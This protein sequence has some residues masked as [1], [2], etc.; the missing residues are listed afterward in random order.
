[1]QDY[2]K[3]L[4]PWFKHLTGLRHALA[5]RIPLYIPQ[6]VIAKS[7]EGAYMDYETKMTEA[8]KQQEF[9]EYDRLSAEQMKLGRFRPWVQHSF[10]EGAK[11]V[12]FHP[13]MLADFNTLDELGNKIIEELDRFAPAKATSNN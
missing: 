12:V 3:T 11:P 9:A 4:D 13:Q 6:H 8:I 10:E 1:L 2:L 5:H 7:Y